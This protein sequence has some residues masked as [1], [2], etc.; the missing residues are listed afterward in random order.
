MPIYDY[1]CPKC[2]TEF[3]VRLT[4]D[5]FESTAL[6][7]NCFSDSKRLTTSFACKTGSS[8]QASERPFRKQARQRRSV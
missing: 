2:H 1:Q 8:L 4:I 5:Q 6:C 7:P 3:E